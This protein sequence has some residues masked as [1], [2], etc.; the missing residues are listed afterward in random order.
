MQRRRT[1][2]RVAQ[3]LY[4]QRKESTISALERRTRHLEEI[5]SGMN[6]SFLG[7]YDAAVKYPDVQ[8]P[9]HVA[10]QLS[11]TVEEFLAFAR[12]LH[13]DLDDA[14]GFAEPAKY[15]RG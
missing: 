2:I 7:L 3:R 15:R 11:K 5:I 12:V 8:N 9:P 14:S 4:R 1:Q 6:N 13:E 10:S